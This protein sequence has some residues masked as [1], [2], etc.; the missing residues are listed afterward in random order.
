MIRIATSRSLPLQLRSGQ[1]LNIAEGL[2]AMTKMK[3]GI[4]FA[5]QILRLRY[6]SLR[7]CPELV[8]GMTRK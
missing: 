5:G 6:A 8:E 2:L 3:D 1:A 4:Y 7:A